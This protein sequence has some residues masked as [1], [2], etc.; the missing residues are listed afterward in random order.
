MILH[1]ELLAPTYYRLARIWLLILT[2]TWMGK[3]DIRPGGR[4]NNP[5][6]PGAMVQGAPARRPVGS[7]GGLDHRK[8]GPL[9][10]AKEHVQG[11]LLVVF[12]QRGLQLAG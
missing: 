8:L 9:T 7:I 1:R 3:P 6:V 12:G 10:P 5:A 2:K 11:L 4:A